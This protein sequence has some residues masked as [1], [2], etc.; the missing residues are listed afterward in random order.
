LKAIHAPLFSPRPSIHTDCHKE[1][2]IA[3]AYAIA[4]FIP[5]NK[6]TPEYIIPSPFEEGFGAA[7]ANA[8]AQ[9]ARKTGAARI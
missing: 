9:A 4:D 1:M 3:A 7:V 8:V 5:E 6:L 2:K